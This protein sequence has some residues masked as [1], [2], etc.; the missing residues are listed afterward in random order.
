MRTDLPLRAEGVHDV[1]HPIEVL[2][3][4]PA[5]A[6]AVQVEHAPQTQ[7]VLAAVLADV[8]QVEQVPVDAHVFDDLGADSMVMARFCARV[9]KQ[10]DLPTVSMKDVYQHPTIHSLAAAL[11]PPSGTD[12]VDTKLAA[13]LADVLQVEQVPV[14]AHVFDDLGADSM[15]MARF[16]ARV[17]KQPDLPTV[18]MKDVYQHPTIHSLAAALAPPSG[19]DSVDTKLA[20]VLADVLQ[21][22]QVPVDAHVFDDLGADSMVMARFCARVRKQP[23]LPT[24]SMKDVYQHPTIHSLAAAV[25]ADV[26]ATANQSVPV[27]TAAPSPAPADTAPYLLCGTLQALFFVGYCLLVAAVSVAGYG[28]ISDGQ[29]PGGLY[30]GAG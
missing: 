7:A 20:A 4:A 19:T 12:S 22:E 18:S 14:D 24:V 28:W 9:R 8:L 2:T 11:A 1:G 17:R 13:V 29:G 26:P 6:P 25:T 27:P 21:V 30:G 3:T 10:P 23:D 16:C 5:A 15:V